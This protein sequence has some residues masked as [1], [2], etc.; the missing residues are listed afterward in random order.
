MSLDAENGQDPK[1]HPRDR[2]R[3]TKAERVQHIAPPLLSPRMTSTDNPA[4]SSSAALPEPKAEQPVQS[5][6]DRLFPPAKSIPDAKSS[7]NAHQRN[8]RGKTS[9]APFFKTL[10]AAFRDEQEAS[11]G[12]TPPSHQPR[13]ETSPDTDPEDIIK[14]LKD[15]YLQTAET[16]Q[17]RAAMQ[18]QLTHSELA[19]KLRELSK[20]EAAFL[21][22]AEQHGESV[23]GAP[24]SQFSIRSRQRG[25]DGTARV[26]KNTAGELDA[27]AQRHLAEFETHVAQLFKEYALAEAE[28]AKAYRALDPEEAVVTAAAD[29]TDYDDVG[30]L[31]ACASSDDDSAAAAAAASDILSKFRAAIETEIEEAEAEAE[32]LG[33]AAAALLK[34]IETE[35]RKKVTPDFHVF[36]KSIEE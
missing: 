4:S 35:Y 23:F 32:K 14:Q 5:F 13:R 22:V 21:A 18:M 6:R 8:S 11:S 7:T 12:A 36:F 34:E 10:E 20:G 9:I 30:G 24:L 19:R 16:L 2:N 26:E 17:E 1:S 25:A 31:P 29:G 33:E 3:Q 27:A 15:H 28:I